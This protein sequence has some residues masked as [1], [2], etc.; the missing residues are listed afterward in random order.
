[1]YILMSSNTILLQHSLPISNIFMTHGHNS[2]LLFNIWTK[3][4][5][6]DFA[7][8]LGSHFVDP[9]AHFRHRNFSVVNEKL[10]KVLESE[11]YKD[12]RN[13]PAVPNP[14]PQDFDSLE[15]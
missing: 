10:K 13:L 7:E 9:V 14:R 12:V 6:S 11:G 3:D 1:M 15:P 4:P 2:G 8:R 5:S